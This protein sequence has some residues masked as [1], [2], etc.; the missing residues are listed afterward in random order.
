LGYPEVTTGNFGCEYGDQSGESPLDLPGNVD[1]GFAAIEI[2]AGRKHTC[3]RSALGEVTCWGV[4]AMGRL[5]YDDET[6]IGDDEVPADAGFIDFGDFQVVQ[7]EAGDEHTCA[8]LDG[9]DGRRRVMCWG[10]AQYGQIGYQDKNAHGDLDGPSIHEAGFVV[11]QESGDELFSAFQVASA[12]ENT[13]ALG[14]DHKSVLCWGRN[15][16][17]EH[18]RDDSVTIGHE[19]GSMPPLPANLGERT[20]ESIDMGGTHVCAVLGG[21]AQGTVECWGLHD[22]GQLGSPIYTE[23]GV[24]AGVGPYVMPPPYAVGIGAEAEA[25][26][27]GPSGSPQTGSSNFSCALLTSGEVTCWGAGSEGQLGS[28]GYENV[29]DDELPSDAGTVDLT[30]EG[31]RVVQLASGG[32]HSCVLIDG[33]GDAAT[34][35]EILRCWGNGTDGAL[36]YGTFEGVPS[37][38]PPDLQVFP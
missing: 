15:H 38:P 13:C 27:I 33:D 35:P 8:R 21:D 9:F 19:L 3:A 31:E 26:S 29:G 25:I 22:L 14:D 37:F 30:S 12:G 10:D 1:V 2:S 32:L 5:G 28:M 4:G 20:I 34:P 23:Q 17:G 16:Q 18:G 24:G 7:I 11:L 36:G 6:N